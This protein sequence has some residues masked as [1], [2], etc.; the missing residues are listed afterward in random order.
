MDLFPARL[1]KLWNMWE[2]RSLVLLSLLIQIFQIIFGSH[3]K[4]TTSK[5]LSIFIWMGYLLAEWVATLALRVLSN[6]E[7]DDSTITSKDPNLNLNKGLVAFWSPFLLLHLGGPDS[8][9]AFSLE[10]NELWLRYLLGLVFQVAVAVY[11]VIRSLP[12]TKFLPATVLRF[13]AGIIKYG[14]LGLG[15][16]CLQ[17]GKFSGTCWSLLRIQVLTI[18]Q[19]H[20]RIFLENKCQDQCKNHMEQ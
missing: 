13:V 14:E 1:R 5:L 4:Y 3:R 8:I 6:S 11:I 7:D 2:L 20:G 17:A 10:D 12:N 15:L 18:C 16:S 19:V 9:T